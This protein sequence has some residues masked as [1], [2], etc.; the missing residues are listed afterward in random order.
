MVENNSTAELL[1]MM[2]KAFGPM[3]TPEMIRP[4]MLG[5]F[6]LLRITGAS[7]M[8]NKIIEKINTGFSSGR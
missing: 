5:M 4:M 8:I 6:I 3:S 2:F 1:R 7:K